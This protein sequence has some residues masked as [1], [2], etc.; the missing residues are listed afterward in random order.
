MTET[1]DLVKKL[2]HLG[3][4][5]VYLRFMQLCDKTLIQQVAYTGVLKPALRC[6]A[7]APGREMHT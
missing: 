4:N 6:L 5:S 3:S 1:D 7:T 2:F